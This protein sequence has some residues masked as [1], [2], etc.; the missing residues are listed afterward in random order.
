MDLFACAGERA[1]HVGER[2][3]CS[4]VYADTQALQHA[5]SSLGAARIN[6]RGVGDSVKLRSARVLLACAGERVLHAGERAACSGVYADTQAL[7]H[8]VSSLGAARINPRGV[9]DSVKL[10]SAR[11]LL[12]C[13]GERADVKM[14]LE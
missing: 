11:V 1:L 8:A 5:V 2:A 13:A 9:G 6:P 14:P 3:A 10:R 12:A 7:Q 4:G